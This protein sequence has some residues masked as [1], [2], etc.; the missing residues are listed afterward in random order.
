[1]KKTCTIC[2]ATSDETSFYDGVNNRC[3]ECHKAKVREN[4]A[5]NVARYRAYDAQRFQDDPRVL[6]RHKRYQSTEAGKASMLASRKKWLEEN[7]DKRAAHVILGNSV[8]CGRI[9]K[10]DKCARCGSGGRIHGHHHDYTKP[11]DVLWLCSKCHHAE[12]KVENEQ[13]RK[14]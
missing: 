4:R 1:M 10:P 5:A 3:A 2:G 9:I 14:T 12:H 13:I 11:L 8:K 7:S 6:A